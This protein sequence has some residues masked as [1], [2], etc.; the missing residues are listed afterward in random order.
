MSS[1]VPEVIVFDVNETLSD[2][3]PLAGRF[4]DVGAPPALAKLWFAAL[5]R[6]GFARTAAGESERFA[7]LA[8]SG[9]HVVLHGIEL[10]RPV[11]AA[12]AHIL[13]GFA[14]LSVHPDV[15]DGVRALRARGLR[16]VTMS[17]GA[18][19]VAEKLLG[20][21]GLRG[22]FEH[23]LSVE[24]AGVWKPAPGSYGYVAEVCGVEAADLLMV[25]VHPWDLDGAARAGLR[26]A[27]IDRTGAPYPGW[28]R[29]P[30][31]VVPGLDHL[32]DAL[33]R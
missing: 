2:M 3:A 26:T 29:A 33:G 30:D 9:L 15:P 7:V 28:C 16:L 12:V 14:G 17:N 19:A 4:A 23:V 18:A 5:L 27:W 22:E 13:D 25:A 8:E 21:A 10:D 11:N 31:H 24:D 20:D 6:D 32:A 1:R